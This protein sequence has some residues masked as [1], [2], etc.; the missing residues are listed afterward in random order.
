MNKRYKYLQKVPM[1]VIAALLNIILVAGIVVNIIDIVNFAGVQFGILPL[2]TVIFSVVIIILTLLMILNTHYTIGEKYFS[3]TIGF[4]FSR[5]E[6]TDILMLREHPDK[7]ILLMYFKRKI[8]GEDYIEHMVINIKPSQFGDFV[9]EIRKQ[10]P[11]VG[12][13]IFREYSPTD[14]KE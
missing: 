4:I 14:S 9:E 8:K 13:E 10:N 12:Y 1:I 11:S 2:F 7:K 6:Y 3:L 5:K